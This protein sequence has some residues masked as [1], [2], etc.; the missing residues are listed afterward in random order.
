MFS[1]SFPHSL[2][3]SRVKQYILIDIGNWQRFAQISFGLRDSRLSKMK[4]FP[5]LPGHGRSWKSRGKH[6]TF[7]QS[8]HSLQGHPA[9]LFFSFRPWKCAKPFSRNAPYRFYT[10]PQPPAIFFNININI[11]IKKTGIRISGKPLL[12]VFCRFHDF[13]SLSQVLVDW[14]SKSAMKN[15]LLIGVCISIYIPPL[16]FKISYSG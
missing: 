1:T 15:K 4:F 8:A 11:N 14:A 10:F 16:Y 7:P 12:K 5:P 3:K 6:P 2:L 9:G 13:E